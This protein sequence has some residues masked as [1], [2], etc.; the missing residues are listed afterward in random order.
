MCIYARMKYVFM[1]MCVYIYVYMK[2]ESEAAQLCLILCNSM[3]YRPPGSSIHGIF[4]DKNTGVGCHFLLQGS[5]RPRGW[6]HV[7]FIA[8][9]HFTVW[10]TR[11]APYIYIYVYRYIYTHTH[12]SIN[13]YLA[14][15]KIVYT[16]MKFIGTSLVGY[17]AVVHCRR[18]GFNLWMEN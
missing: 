2:S 17:T 14:S 6:T 13:W 7:S 15:Y 18:H 10:A 12:K 8:G 1:C 16:K 5:S 4:P 3:G 11:E 9:R